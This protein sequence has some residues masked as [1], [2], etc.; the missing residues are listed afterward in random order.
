M[1]QL[2]ED[3]LEDGTLQS[4]EALDALTKEAATGL[5]INYASGKV[6][7]DQ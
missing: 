3:L 6:D 5:P 7:D 1:P 2:L 4:L